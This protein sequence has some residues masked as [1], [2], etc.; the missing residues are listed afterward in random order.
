MSIKL[1]LLKSGEDVVADVQ[2]MVVEEK[3]V[4]YILRYPARAKLVGG[5]DVQDG[6]NSTPFKLQLTPWMPLSKEKSIPIVA[7]W[8]ITMTEPVDQLVTMFKQGVEDYESRKS[9]DSDPAVGEGDSDS[10]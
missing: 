5:A 10:D 7:D 8:V 3:V 6:N 9:A 1:L 2:E 4:G